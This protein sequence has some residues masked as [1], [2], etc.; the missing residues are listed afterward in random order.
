METRFVWNNNKGSD[1]NVK[2]VK[3][4]KKLLSKKLIRRKSRN[5]TISK[6]LNI[7]SDD[8][9]HISNRTCAYHLNRVLKIFMLWKKSSVNDLPIYWNHWYKFQQINDDKS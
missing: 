9:I 8:S 3:D 5:L 7:S 1:S 6:I 4:S 2:G